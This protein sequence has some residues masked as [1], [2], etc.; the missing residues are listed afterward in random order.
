[1]PARNVALD[2]VFVRFTLLTM[3]TSVNDKRNTSLFCREGVMVTAKRGA[4]TRERATET[5]RAHLGQQ[6]LIRWTRS[7]V[8]RLAAGA[9]GE[10]SRRLLRRLPG[11]VLRKQWLPDQQGTEADP[12][13]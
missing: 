1:M 4:F 2:H 12:A 7:K 5:R 6:F 13:S 3:Q 8:C 11:K 10:S 9:S